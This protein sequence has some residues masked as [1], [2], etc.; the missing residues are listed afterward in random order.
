MVSYFHCWLSSIEFLVLILVLTNPLTYLLESQPNLYLLLTG[1]KDFLSLSLLTDFPLLF[2]FW[3]FYEKS[4]VIIYII[5]RFL[6]F[7]VPSHLLY[8]ANMGWWKNC[9]IPLCPC[10]NHNIYQSASTSSSYASYC[11]V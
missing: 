4:I 5:S 10:I 11:G 2:L 9:K 7:P 3:H 1:R 6:S 8:K